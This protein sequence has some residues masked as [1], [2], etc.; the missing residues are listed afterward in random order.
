MAKENKNKKK[1]KKKKS[2]HK[3][4]LLFG[5]CTF[6]SL[7]V[8]CVFFSTPFRRVCSHAKIKT[9][10]KSDPLNIPRNTKK[11]RLLATHFFNTSIIQNQQYTPKKG[12]EQKPTPTSLGRALPPLFPLD[13]LPS[14]VRACDVA[15]MLAPA[16]TQHPP[17]HATAPLQQQGTLRA[18]T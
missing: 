15:P 2:T 18:P 13:L 17:P 9:K 16:G 10:Q 8:K 3:R 7:F 6:R 14:L 1:K 12:I 4:T 5:V 11:K